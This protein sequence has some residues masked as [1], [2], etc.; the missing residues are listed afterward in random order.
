MVNPKK[1]ET[2][3]FYKNLFL[4]ITLMVIFVSC[5]KDFTCTCYDHFDN[6]ISSDEYK[7]Q[8]FEKAKEN[9][10]NEI[11]YGSTSRCELEEII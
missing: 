5:K 8:N 1:I 11:N 10:G 6:V 3:K 7:A 9:C 4:T 2:M